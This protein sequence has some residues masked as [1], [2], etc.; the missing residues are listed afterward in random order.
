[1][2]AGP[3]M[4]S[5][6]L[7]R[8]ARTASAPWHRS[9]ITHRSE[10]AT[11]PPQPLG[12]SVTK[13]T[14]HPPNGRGCYV[15]GPR[16]D[17]STATPLYLEG[18]TNCGAGGQVTGDCAKGH[19]WSGCSVRIELWSRLPPA[20]A[21]AHCPSRSLLV[22]SGP[23]MCSGPVPPGMAWVA[24]PSKVGGGWHGGGG[25]GEQ[26]LAHHGPCPLHSSRL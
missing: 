12:G 13:L 18:K 25:G 21:I 8:R 15:R 6:V 26:M 5:R 20:T 3:S 22:H 2:G 14:P 7:V 10:G 17:L 16:S 1:M 4:A 9:V 11:P 19:Q 24:K 23:P